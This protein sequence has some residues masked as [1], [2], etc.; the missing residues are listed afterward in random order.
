MYLSFYKL[1]EKPFQITTDPKFLWLGE[2]H[3]EALAVLKYGIME[4]MGFLLLTGD[5]GTGKTTLINSLSNS[6]G[7]N[8]I[9]TKVPDPS[10]EKLD[11]LNYV[12]HSFNIDKTFDNKGSFLIQFEKFLTDSYL[13][14]K[15]VL[16]IIDEAQRLDS[17]LLEEIR[18]LSNI[19]RE[20]T[21][22]LNIFFVGQNEFNQ[23]L[24]EEQNRA[25]RQRI[26]VNYE[27]FPLTAQETGDYIRFRLKVA[28]AKKKIFSSDAI[29]EVFRFSDGFPRLINIICA[30]AL[31]TGF[32]RNI[33]SI[34]AD[35]IGECAKE[36]KIPIKTRENLNPTESSD[37]KHDRPSADAPNAGNQ[38]P[39]STS[40]SSENTHQ[41]LPGWPPGNM[42]V[43]TTLM[44]ILLLSAFSIYYL[45]KLSVSKN[46]RNHRT[47]Q[48]D[49]ID[50]GEQSPEKSS[51]SAKNKRQQ[52]EKAYPLPAKTF[53]IYFPHNSNE[54]SGKVI[55]LLD[56]IAQIMIQHP[57]T[58]IT[59]SGH[60][61]ALGDSDYNKKLSLFRA[62][63]VKS[64]LVGKGANYLLIKTT[65][66]GS[67]KPVQDN[68]TIQG[69]RANRRV[70]IR[71]LT[72]G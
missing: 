36:L 2:K 8:I 53:T 5:V 33:K 19:E 45:G 46:D 7:D 59:I 71:F 47:R 14:N 11:F 22:L 28:G 3:K 34:K 66:M 35:V 42:V 41:W 43:Y 50:H 24:A 23:I 13:N 17:D 72:K 69:R 38:A 12:A 48:V 21:K 31:L 30:H 9:F 54:F 57:K 40:S 52:S 49:Q 64:Y 60:T 10:M 6:M 67:G 61:D 32:V 16:L 4:N 63:M 65:G 44:I 56:H 1:S 37:I 39:R 58:K 68:A 18:L 55:T 25:L 20:N 62:N 29:H 70:E 51:T 26:T 15:K 27:I